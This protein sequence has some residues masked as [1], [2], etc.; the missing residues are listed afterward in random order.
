MFTVSFL[1]VFLSPSAGPVL[2][3]NNGSEFSGYVPRYV[4]LSISPLRSVE[5]NQIV[6]SIVGANQA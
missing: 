2:H 1:S 6:I 5:N 3:N 4:G